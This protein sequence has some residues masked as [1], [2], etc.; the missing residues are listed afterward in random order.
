MSQSPHKHRRL[1]SPVPWEGVKRWGTGPTEPCG[2]LGEPKGAG[3]PRGGSEV[4]SD[5]GLDLQARGQ[6]GQ[7]ARDSEVSPPLASGCGGQG[8]GL[9]L[10]PG[11]VP[12]GSAVCVF[13]KRVPGTPRLSPGRPALPSPPT[14]GP[15][16]CSAAPASLPCALSRPVSLINGISGA[17]LL[18][19]GGSHTPQSPANHPSGLWEEG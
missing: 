2:E 19:P 1:N 18:G 7:M 11:G 10:G 6:W 16:V 15:L 8:G 9:F 5:F 13:G 17:L 12:E 3:G 14:A 4:K